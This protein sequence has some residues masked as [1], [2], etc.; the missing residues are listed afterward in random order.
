[1]INS[2]QIKF[3]NNYVIIYEYV[4]YYM[5]DLLITNKVF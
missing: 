4:L 5:V 3:Y 1:M 2:L